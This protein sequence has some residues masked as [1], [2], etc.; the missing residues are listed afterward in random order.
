MRRPALTPSNATVQL[1]PVWMRWISLVWFLTWFPLY[2][3]YWGVAN[4]I[5]LCDVAVILTCIGMW[6][7]SRLLISSQAVGALL[8]DAV[9]AADAAW[10]VFLHRELLPG[11][12]YLLDPSY[13]LWVRLLSFFHVCMPVLLLWGLFRAGY[14]RRGWALQSAIAFPLFAI[15]RFTSSQ[16]NINFAFTD[17]FLHRQWGP[18]PAHILI[19]WLFMVFVVY[20]PMHLLLKRC[21]ATAGESGG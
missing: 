12:E 7:N 5:H 16:K 1:Y 9:W 2:W 20:W 4:F 8:V 13:P 3:H 21:F 11:N 17:P 10:I 14:D 6:T 18:A 15:A 19:S